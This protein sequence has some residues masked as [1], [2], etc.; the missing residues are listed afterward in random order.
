MKNTLSALLFILFVISVIASYFVI[1]T[2]YY[3]FPDVRPQLYVYVIGL[4]FIG[5]IAWAEYATACFFIHR[6]NFSIKFVRYAYF[7]EVVMCFLYTI[8]ISIVV[9]SFFE[10]LIVFFHLFI[11]LCPVQAIMLKTKHVQSD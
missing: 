3:L 4:F 2:S 8:F 9:S 10:I 11:L 1:L 6:K 7:I 5:A